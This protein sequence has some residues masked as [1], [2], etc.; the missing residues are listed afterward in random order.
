MNGCLI[1]VNGT[2]AVSLTAAGQ[3]APSSSP[4]P[5][6]SG[7]AIRPAPAPMPPP[8]SRP[9]AVS[10]PTE[11]IEAPP[12]WLHRNVARFIAT[13]KTS[14]PIQLAVDGRLPELSLQEGRDRRTTAEGGGGSN[15]LVLTVVL[16]LSVV[17]ST[18]LLFVDFQPPQSQ[19][20]SRAEARRKL[21]EFYREP[22]EELK[23]Y[24]QYLREAQQAHSRGDYQTERDQYRRVLRLLRSEGRSR[25]ASLTRTPREDKE[26][27]SL[28]AILLAEE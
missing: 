23:P 14:S 17:M 18:A 11:A 3:G 5:T 21:A 16:C 10:T 24:Q 27:E 7:T 9:P 22:R 2:S 8:A 13:E 19:F 26:L 28:L 12:D 15:P 6:G 25:F 1:Q 20:G 4:S